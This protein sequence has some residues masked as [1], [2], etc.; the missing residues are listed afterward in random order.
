MVTTRLEALPG[1]DGKS[2]KRCKY[3]AS[4]I[5][6]ASSRCP[7]CKQFCHSWLRWLAGA[8]AW[9]VFGFLIMI[10]LINCAGMVLLDS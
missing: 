9:L 10:W 7:H 4:F 5:P 2:K 8:M 1:T 3:C 6:V